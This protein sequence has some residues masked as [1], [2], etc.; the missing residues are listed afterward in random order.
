MMRTDEEQTKQLMMNR[1]GD[2][3][4]T[5]ARKLSEKQKKTIYRYLQLFFN[6]K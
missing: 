5:K 6:Q 2:E 3:F 1:M 4:K